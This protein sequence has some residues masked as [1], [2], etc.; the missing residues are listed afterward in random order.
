MGSIGLANRLGWD[1]EGAFNDHIVYVLK[2][3]SAGNSW[4]QFSHNSWEQFSHKLPRFVLKLGI[5][6]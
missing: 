4:E 1:I 5:F 2:S 3:V 6:P